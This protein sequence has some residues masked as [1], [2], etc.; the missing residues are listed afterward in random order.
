MQIIFLSGTKCLWLPKYVNKFLF[1]QKNLDQL[2]T[3]WDLEKDQAKDYIIFFR[4]LVILLPEVT[5]NQKRKMGWT[6][7]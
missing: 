3:F 5:K 1:L 2:K 7:E 6:K 4:I